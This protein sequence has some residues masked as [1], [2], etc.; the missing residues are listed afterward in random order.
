MVDW[1]WRKGMQRSDIILIYIHK[2][3]MSLRKGN[4]STISRNELCKLAGLEIGSDTHQ[5]QSLIYRKGL[6]FPPVRQFLLGLIFAQS[7]LVSKSGKCAKRALSLLLA[8]AEEM[9]SLES[10]ALVDILQFMLPL[11]NN[12]VSA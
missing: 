2:L 5:S 9:P 10:P 12:R 1:R 4:P 3:T 7:A 6:G 8:A 11:R